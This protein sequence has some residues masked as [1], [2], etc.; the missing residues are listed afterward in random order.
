MGVLPKGGTLI[1]YT[2]N[3]EVKRIPQQVEG[4][5]HNLSEINFLVDEM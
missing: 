3:K 1:F 5:L 4:Q 2:Y